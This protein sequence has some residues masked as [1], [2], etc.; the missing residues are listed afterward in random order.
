MTLGP[1]GV[2]VHS[3]VRGKRSRGSVP[4]STLAAS[5]FTQHVHAALG[6][7]QLSLLVIYWCPSCPIPEWLAP[8]LPVLGVRSFFVCCC[9]VAEFLLLLKKSGKVILFCFLF[10]KKAVLLRFLS[11]RPALVSPPLA[12]CT[13]YLASDIRPP[14]V[15][16]PAAFDTFSFFFY[17]CHVGF[18]IYF[19][20]SQN[21]DL[22]FRECHEKLFR[23]VAHFLP[24]DRRDRI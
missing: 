21:K 3:E 6:G 22:V 11:C 16:W 5:F 14:P 7:Q 10:L 8:P 24:S 15:Y 9:R 12:L 23:W 13:L 17:W 1:Q 4:Q 18:G 2:V 20:L 19:Q